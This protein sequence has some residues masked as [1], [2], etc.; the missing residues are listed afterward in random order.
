MK[1]L[2]I[3]ATLLCFVACKDAET[4]EVKPSEAETEQESVKVELYKFDGGQVTA[5]KL[6]LF[7]EGDKYK[8]E[9]KTLADGFYLIKHPKGML[10]WDTG[11]PENLVGNEPYTTPDGGFTITRKDSIVNQLA[12]INVTP[13][14]VNYIA[15]SHIHFDHTG[16]ANHFKNSEWLVQDSE[17]KFA[18]GDSI[19]GNSFYAPASFSEL[20]KVVQLSGD[21]DVFGDGTV[22][23][24]NMPGHTIGHQVLMVRL[25]ETGNVLLSGDMYHFEQNRE[26]SVVPQFNYSIPQSK[27]S[28]AEFE[29]FA[30]Q[31][32]AKVII[33]HDAKDFSEM[34]A[35]LN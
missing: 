29:E 35:V 21:H 31:N 15:F 12:T 13:Q 26:E 1:Q 20:K 9:S 5:N 14:D 19:K 10:L 32:N 16:A 7:S 33:Q 30:K 27:K 2:F 4:K 24:K 34:P 23:I 18:N 22:V 28:I 6:S 3:I 17:Y 25:P 11:L 8:G